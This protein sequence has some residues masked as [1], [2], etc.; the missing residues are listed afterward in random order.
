VI[1]CTIRAVAQTWTAWGMPPRKGEAG[2]PPVP[3]PTA[4]HAVTP[5]APIDPT[6]RPD[7]P[8]GDWHRST[9]GVSLVFRRQGDAERFAASLA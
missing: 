9:D 7:A 2:R 5:N 1:I 6:L 3:Q 4:W 8:D